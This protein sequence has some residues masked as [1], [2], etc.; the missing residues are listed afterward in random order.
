MGITSQLVSNAYDKKAAKRAFRFF[1]FL[2]YYYY[3]IAPQRRV[4]AV[5]I[6]QKPFVVT[7]PY[8]I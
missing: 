5:K 1:F 3:P 2:T 7:S 6:D 4:I 8:I